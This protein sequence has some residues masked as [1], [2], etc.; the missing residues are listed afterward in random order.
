MNYDIVLHIGANKTGSSAIQRFV[1]KNR[2]SLLNRGFAIPDRTLGWSDKVTGEHVF[3]LQSWISNGYAPIEVE[4]FIEQLESTKPEGKTIFISAE[5]LSN[6]GS[7]KIFTP[8][9]K[10]RVKVIFYIRRQDDIIA[11]SWQQWHSKVQ[12]EFDAWLINALQSIGHWEQVI[13]DWAE[14]VGRDNIDVA[15]FDR[16]EF[17]D[18]DILKDFVTRL[19]L[20]PEDLAWDYS[21]SESNPSFSDIITP[22]VAGN[23]SIFSDVHDNEFYKIVQEFTGT[24]YSKRKKVSLMTRVQRDNIFNYFKDQNERIKKQHFPNRKHLFKPIDHNKYN[25]LTE[26]EIKDEQLRFLTEF[27]YQLAK[28]IKD[29]S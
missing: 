15:I 7:A 26:D 10:R 24:S 23:T 16:E 11:S 22:L 25:Y 27:V 6:L 29:M 9:S 20:D 14:I 5:N 8:L 19:E 18:G 2:A 17:H 3:T 4:G 1:Q 13:N 28:R 12:S 21:F